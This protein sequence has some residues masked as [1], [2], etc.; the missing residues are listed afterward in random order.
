M[1]TG[2]G[3][4]AVMTVLG[5]MVAGVSTGCVSSSTYELAKSNAENAKLL[6]QNEQRRSQELAATAKQM[7]LQL[8]TLEATLRDTREKLERTDRDWREARDELLR[9]KIEREQQRRKGRERVVETLS[10][11]EAEK[12]ASAPDPEALLKQQGQSDETKRRLKELMQQLQTAL[13]HY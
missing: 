11:I 1:K 2:A 5:W 10:R 3:R 13:E 6:Y 9:V 8:E 12:P 4:I 7:K